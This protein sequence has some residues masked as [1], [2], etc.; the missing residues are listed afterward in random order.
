M[1]ALITNEISGFFSTLT[2]YIVII[3]F[4]LLNGLFIWVFPG[5]NN[6]LETGYASLNSLFTLAPWIFLFLVPAVTM[7]SFAEEKKTG[8]LELLLTR[9]LSDVQ[10]I[11]SKYIAGVLLVVFALL[12]TF[13]YLLSIY[14]L[15]SPKGNFDA[16]G[17]WGSYLGLFFLASIYIS[18]GIFASSLTENQIIAFIVA[19]L[20]C[21]FIYIG[22]DFIGT[23]NVFQSIND[24]VLSLG[25][26]EH[27]RSISRGVVDTRDVVYFLGVNVIFIT[28]TWLKLDSRKW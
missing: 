15:G 24:I 7:R 27:Y 11:L 8:T 6:I 21:F 10:I 28:F 20:I 13:I 19:V 25:I 2:G 14:F 1:R 12:P 3:V 22:F 16:G 18:I 23:M 9:P 17:T 26:E 5:E 4:L